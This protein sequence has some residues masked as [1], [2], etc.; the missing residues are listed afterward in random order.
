MTNKEQYQKEYTEA[1]KK[2]KSI[3]L[4]ADIKEIDDDGALLEFPGKET[5]YLKIETVITS[6]AIV[7]NRV[8]PLPGALK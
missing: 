2:L 1:L 4:S 5:V 8:T 6:S 3:F 7:F